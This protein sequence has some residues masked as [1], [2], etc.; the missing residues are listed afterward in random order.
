[1]SETSFEH[2][3]WCYELAKLPEQKAIELDPIYGV[4][5]FDG[6]RNPG[7]R[8]ATSHTVW[9]TYRTAAND[10][11]E[12]VGVCE[13]AAEA[14]VAREALMSPETLDVALQPLT[15]SYKLDG[16]P[17]EYTHDILI[18]KHNGHRRLIF[19]RNGES[20]SKPQTWR[21]IEAIFKATPRKAANDLIV[22]DADEY[23][24][25]RRENLFRMLELVEQPDDEADEIV[26]H[27]ARNL[28]TLWQIKDIFPHTSLTQDRAFRACYRLIACQ[29]LT[30]NLDHVIHET[31]RVQVAA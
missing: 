3:A 22:V 17:R 18:T 31:S 4:L 15:V 21:E 9:M 29:K 26:F 25:Q 6:V 1:M 23:T 20:L 7:F 2:D 5:P 30:A 12:K 14:A 16:A 27:T 13:S 8:S 19:V 10:W 24:R 11:K 28:K